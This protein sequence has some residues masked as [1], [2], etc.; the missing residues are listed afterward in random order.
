MEAPLNKPRIGAGVCPYQRLGGGAFKALA[1]PLKKRGGSAN[2]VWGPDF[3]RTTLLF[4]EGFK[5]RGQTSF[6]QL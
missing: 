6:G 3:F 1:N 2:L 4:L 5:F